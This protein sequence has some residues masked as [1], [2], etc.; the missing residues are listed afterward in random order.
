[1]RYSRRS[2]AKLSILFAISFL[3]LVVLFRCG[4]LPPGFLDPVPHRSTLIVD[5]YG[6]PLYES[7]SQSEQRSHWITA[8]QVPHNVEMA[9]LAAEDHRFFH[10]PGID[11]IA[12]S[13]ALLHDAIARRFVEGG[14]TISQQTV[15]Q[16]LLARGETTTGRTI[17]GKLREMLLALRLEHHL[18]K[19]EILALYLNLA[20]YGNQYVGIDRASRGYFN[21]PAAS[22]TYAQA[23]FLAG[24]PRK[25]SALDPWSNR[26]AAIERQRRVLRRMKETGLISPEETALAFDEQ[27]NLHVGSRSNPAPHFV[28]HVLALP[29]SRKATRIETTLDLA[30]QQEIRGVIAMHARSLD[31]HGAHNLGVVVLDNATGDWLAWVGSRDY[32]DDRYGGAIDAVR[33]PRQPGSALKPFTY[34]LAFDSGFDP[35]TVLPDVAVDFATAEEG[36]RYKPRNYDG[37]YRGPLRARLALAGSENVPAVWLLSRIGVSTLL[38]SLRASSFSTLDRDPDHYGLGLTL[39]DAEVR[40]DELVRAYAM[41]ARLGE[42][43]ETRMIRRIDGATSELRDRSVPTRTIS[44]RSAFWITD[45]LSD[46]RAREYVFGA[47]GPLDFPFEVAVKTGTSQAY[48]DNWT[49]GY[50]HDVTVGVWVGNVD[51]TPLRNSSGS[52]GA[53][54]VFHDVMMAAVRR[55]HGRIPAGEL[56]PMASPPED[57]ARAQV[58]ALSGEQPSG[59]CPIREREWIDSGTS[60]RV[61]SWHQGDGVSWPP[62]YRDWARANGRANDVPLSNDEGL[63]VSPSSMIGATVRIINPG[64]DVLYW[65]DPTLRPEYQTLALRAVLSGKAGQTVKW[66]V[67]DDLIGTVRADVPLDWPLRRGVHR[68]TAEDD[69]GNR[70]TVTITVR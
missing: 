22:L 3:A 42:P 32:F 61:C 50:T 48:R 49:I 35:S 2:F 5:R 39:G 54:P 70:D 1:M 67:D 7:L 17:S 64:E 36:V 25:P 16:I 20:P 31:R 68:I 59:F 27:L 30:L 28:E 56:R 14:S 18:D 66:M 8:D 55:R 58:C 10:H 11:P 51:R 23:A 12:I 40:L 46:P 29:E 57:L 26:S 69:A 65:I 53:A 43:L 38:S 6:E 34:A 47:G 33:A 21:V 4:P 9:T 45:I 19:R 41:L 60:R 52:T 62:E 44:G 15:K 37:V 13:R 24:L 63:E